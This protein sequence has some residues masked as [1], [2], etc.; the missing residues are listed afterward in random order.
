MS[1]PILRREPQAPRPGFEPGTL[2]AGE[3]GIATR[4]S[5]KLCI[6]RQS[7]YRAGAERATRDRG[8]ATYR[9]APQVSASGFEPPLS[10]A[11]GRRLGRARPRTLQTAA[12]VPGFEPGASRFASECSLRAEPYVLPQ[13]SKRWCRFI[14]PQE[15]ADSNYRISPHEGA[16]L[17]S[18]SVPRMRGCRHEDSNLGRPTPAVLSRFLLTTWVW[19]HSLI[20]F[21]AASRMRS[22]RFERV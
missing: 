11:S 22:T 21:S 5:T 14:Q 20:L 13:M 1:F 9:T 4:C 3:Y 19:R 17:R 12:D 15:R 2:R 6:P 16:V 18:F 8:T 7:N 10:S